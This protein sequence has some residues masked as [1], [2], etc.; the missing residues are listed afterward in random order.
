MAFTDAQKSKRFELE[1]KGSLTPAEELLLAALN[2][3][4]DADKSGDNIEGC[5]EAVKQ[6]EKAVKGEDK[7][8]ELKNKVV[9]GGDS[10]RRI[11]DLQEQ[12]NR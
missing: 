7:D 8:P 11:Q 1:N 5:E 12:A 2:D 3:L 6:A 9:A 4:R 10:V